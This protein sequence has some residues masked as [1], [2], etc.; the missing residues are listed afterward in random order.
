MYLGKRIHPPEMKDVRDVLEQAQKKQIKDSYLISVVTPVFGGGVK[1]GE[2]KSRPTIRNSSIRGH[3]RFWWR[4]TR[5]AAYK[6]ISELRKREAQIFGDTKTSSRVKIWVESN[7]FRQNS[8]EETLDLEILSYVTFPFKE[9]IPSFKLPYIFQLNIEFQPSKF[10]T[11]KVLKE[12]LDP[13]LWA[14]INFGG[15]GS[16]T[17]RGCGSLYCSHFSPNS[18][19]TNLETWYR[20]KV[21]NYQLK[22]E[23]Q[24]EREWPTLSNE[25]QIQKPSDTSTISSWQDAIRVYKEFRA[26]PNKSGSKRRS[27]WPEADSLRRKTKMSNT[28]HEEPKPEGKKEFYA[29]PR[30]QL[31]LPIIFQF[32]QDKG[33][34][35]KPLHQWEPLKM[36]LKPK[37]K[38]RLA[39]PLIVKS[40]ALDEKTGV[41]AFIKL[42]QP[43]IKKLELKIIAKKPKNTGD[44]VFADHKT[45]TAQLIKKPILENDIY[46]KLRYVDNPLGSTDDVIEAFF[47][48]KGVEQWK[49]GY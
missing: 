12:E 39:S 37:Q 48:S 26:M 18:S 38:N 5:G 41:G 45:K 36:I 49:K 4:A 21:L 6:D 31:G 13:A 7:S 28:R 17:R 16:R 25:L 3:L 44:K 15:I 34:E 10:L 35:Y 43:R 24:P 27:F 22:L 30:A 42:N 1:A 23:P 19:M 40:I 47:K 33:Y 9:E 8:S 46:K 2:L 11:S 32:K 29:F 14:W 20:D